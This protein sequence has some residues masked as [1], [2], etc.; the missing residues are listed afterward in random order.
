[1]DK[2]DRPKLRNALPKSGEAALSFAT[3][4]THV[5]AFSGCNSGKY[6]TTSMVIFPCASLAK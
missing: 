5:F 3:Y 6:F 2:Q 4:L 1:M